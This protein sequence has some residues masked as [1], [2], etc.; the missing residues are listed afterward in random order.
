[1][2]SFVWFE[3]VRCLLV[4]CLPGLLDSCSVCQLVASGTLRRAEFADKKREGSDRLVF[5]VHPNCLLHS[6]L[7]FLS[8]KSD[9]CSSSCIEFTDDLYSLK[10][11]LTP[12]FLAFASIEAQ[13]LSQPVVK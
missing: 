11:R 3:E 6:E 8:L 13:N 2:I 4:I 12:Q 1:M 10:L 9:L 5:V 7:F